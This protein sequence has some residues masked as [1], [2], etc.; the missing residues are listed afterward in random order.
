ML[1]HQK[2]LNS[3][4]FLTGK[5]G[6]GCAKALAKRYDETSELL[7]AFYDGVVVHDQKIAALETQIHVE[8]E[9]LKSHVQEL[10]L[11][12]QALREVK[13]DGAISSEAA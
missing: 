2:N 4:A 10:E 9:R 3:T 12:L 7:L 13:K 6:L 8:L 11:Q 5:F 1:K